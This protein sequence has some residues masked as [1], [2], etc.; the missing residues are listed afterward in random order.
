MIVNDLRNPSNEV[1]DRDTYTDVLHS[2]LNTPNS[3]VTIAGI[4]TFLAHLYADNINNT[5]LVYEVK[6]SDTD[7]LNKIPNITQADAISLGKTTFA[8]IKSSDSNKINIWR[9]AFVADIQDRGKCLFI[10]ND[11]SMNS[12]K[13]NANTDST[14]SYSIITLDETFSEDITQ[15]KSYFESDD[16]PSAVEITAKD[17]DDYI[18]KIIVSYVEDMNMENSVAEAATRQELYIKLKEQVKASIDIGKS[19]SEI[20]KDLE[21]IEQQVKDQIAANKGVTTEHL[22]KDEAQ[23]IC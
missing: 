17:I 5:Q 14:Q 11:L 3:P 9:P 7:T 23:P 19:N 22:N 13:P 2:V 18:S 21:K 12:D 10:M 6:N 4:R 16:D 15:S 20:Y 1:I 8:C